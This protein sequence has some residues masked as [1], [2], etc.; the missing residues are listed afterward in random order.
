MTV[1]I[2]KKGILSK[3]VGKKS[4]QKKA[5]LTLVRTVLFN[6]EHCPFRLL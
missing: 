1:G 6:L 3:K 4:T 2:G 5:A